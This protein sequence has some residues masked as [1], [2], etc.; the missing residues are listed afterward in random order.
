MVAVIQ[1]HKKSVH[2][3]L[4]NHKLKCV[5][6]SNHDSARVTFSALAIPVTIPGL[7]VL[8]KRRV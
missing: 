7:V 4:A 6:S 1:H 8:E 2:A 5:L 3:A